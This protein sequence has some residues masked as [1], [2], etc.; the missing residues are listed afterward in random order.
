MQS[1]FAF[2]PELFPKS[3]LLGTSREQIG[4]QTGGRQEGEREL[5]VKKMSGGYF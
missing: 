1:Y 5:S 2:V 4:N 3:I